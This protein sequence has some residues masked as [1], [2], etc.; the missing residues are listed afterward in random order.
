MDQR[1]TSFRR[2]TTAVPAPEFLE[3]DLREL[4]ASQ[5]VARYQLRFESKLSLRTKS[6]ETE[7]SSVVFVWA[8]VTVGRDGQSPRSLGRAQLDQPVFFDPPSANPFR[9]GTPG[10]SMGALV[11]ELD[12]RQL[13]TIEDLRLGGDLVFTFTLKG[14]VHR[15]GEV[16]FLSPDNAVYYQESQSDWIK[17]LASLGYSDYLTLD[18]A[19]PA[20]NLS[21]APEV[22]AAAASLRE[23]LAAL[24]RNECEEAVADCRPGFKALCAA[25]DKLFKFSLNPDAGKD[26]RFWRTCRAGLAIAHAAH[27]PEEALDKDTEGPPQRI[28]WDRADALGV[29]T[30]LAA[31]TRQR[32]GQP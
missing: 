13:E 30:M 28:H 22:A 12:R 16:D 10:A 8:D 29:I 3:L 20:G 14:V 25:G 4:T 32:L 18:L 9:R 6:S 17:L 11:L 15:S 21:S 5:G 23:A 7:P 1:S 31:L 26:E 24:T 27:H 2:L 19:L